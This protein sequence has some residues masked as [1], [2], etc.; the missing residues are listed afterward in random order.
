MRLKKMVVCITKKD[1][2]N[3]LKLQDKINISDIFIND[4]LRLIGTVQVFGMNINIET[5]LSFSKVEHN[6]IYLNIKSFKV[7]KMNI[8]NPISKKVFN[9]VINA[10][11]DIEGVT[12]EENDFKLEVTT[13]I[14]KYYKEQKFIDLNK[15]Q[16]ID[17]SIVDKEVE[18]YFGGIDID[19]EVIRREYGKNEVPYV[20]AEIV[21]D[22]E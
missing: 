2:R 13:L 3:F 15:V 7:L 17:V 18:V 22:G 8:L 5:E 19:T 16:V 20:E 4:Y 14:N 6:N 12:F 21:S 10:F 1:I 11:T 9:Y